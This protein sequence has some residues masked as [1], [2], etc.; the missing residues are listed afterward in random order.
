MALNSRAS[1]HW[2]DHFIIF[3]IEPINFFLALNSLKHYSII[4]LFLLLIEIFLFEF[5]YFICHLV[6]ILHNALNAG[7]SN[8]VKFCD[9]FFQ[10]AGV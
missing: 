8:C 4:E 1:D 10:F 5:L 3:E 2:D 6:A 7:V 9:L